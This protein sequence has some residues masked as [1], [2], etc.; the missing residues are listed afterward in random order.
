[1][2]L[3]GGAATRTQIDLELDCLDV[4]RSSR[5]FLGRLG[6]CW[7]TA[8]TPTGQ[9]PSVNLEYNDASGAQKDLGTRCH[10]RSI[11]TV[12]TELAVH[13]RGS[14]IKR[15]GIVDRKPHSCQ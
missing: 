6:P 9:A 15:L 7:P 5:S 14:E 4:A 1:M 3:Q 10:C 8:G 13:N 12:T 11:A 2:A